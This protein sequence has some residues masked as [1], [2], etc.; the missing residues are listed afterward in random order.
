MVFIL[1]E[2]GGYF[3][4]QAKRK[5]MWICRSLAVFF[6]ALAVAYFAGNG[7]VNVRPA[8]HELEKHYSSQ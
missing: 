8:L 4:R 3:R 1:L 2:L 6:A 7:F 5:Q